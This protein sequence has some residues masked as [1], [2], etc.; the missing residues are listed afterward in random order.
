MGEDQEK[1][2]ITTRG[3]WLSSDHIWLRDQLKKIDG[4]SMSVRDMY[5]YLRPKYKLKGN[6]ISESY[7]RK[8][9]QDFRLHS[10]ISRLEAEIKQLEERLSKIK[11]LVNVS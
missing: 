10:Y 1:L 3:N 8:L 4:G 9:L 2:G 7:F 11:Y 6:F 5:L